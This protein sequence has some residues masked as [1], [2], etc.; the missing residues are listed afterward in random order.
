MITEIPAVPCEEGEVK[1]QVLKAHRTL[2]SISDENA[3]A[4]KDLVSSLERP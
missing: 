4:F 3:D 1:K 2:M